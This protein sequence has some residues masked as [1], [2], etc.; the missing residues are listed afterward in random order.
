MLETLASFAMSFWYLQRHGIPFRD[1]WFSFGKL[2]DNI[3]EA[4][5]KMRLNEASSI[6]FVNLV[7]MQWFNLMAT[8]TRRLSIFQHPPLF[9]KKTQNLYLFPSIVFS[10]GMAVIW[11][12]I[13]SIQT[14]IDT[15][16]VPV[17]HWFLPFTFGLAIILLD[18]ARR[19]WV[20]RWPNG[21]LA[22]AAW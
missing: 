12:Y 13:P 3:D 2:P 20:R 14:I 11:L 8:R 7:V 18:E 17:E 10:L 16:A 15:A 21:L 19:F 6:Y 22:K 1:L 4:Y 5:Y 9:N